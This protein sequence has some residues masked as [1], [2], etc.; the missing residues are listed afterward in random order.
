LISLGKEYT[1]EE[2]DGVRLEGMKN[3]AGS[4]I[5]DY[6]GGYYNNPSTGQIDPDCRHLWMA[7]TRLRKK[8][9]K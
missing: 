6:R 8:E 1:F 2:I 3:V 4:S 9:K 5:W 7:E